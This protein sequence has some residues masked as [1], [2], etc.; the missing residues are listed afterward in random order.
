MAY[1]EQ[2]L[3][4]DWLYSRNLSKLNSNCVTSKE[5]GHGRGLPNLTGFCPLGLKPNMLKSRGASRTD[6]QADLIMDKYFDFL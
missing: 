4:R 2:E 6:T 3:T 1:F 5:S